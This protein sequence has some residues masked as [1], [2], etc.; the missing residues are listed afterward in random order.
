MIAVP[1]IRRSNQARA[2]L[3]G[4][5]AFSALYLG[6][7]TLHLVTPTTLVPGAIDAAIPL[8][9]WTVWIYLSQFLLLPGAIAFARDDTDRSQTFYAMLLAAV[10]AALIF[11]AWPTTMVRQTPA[12]D[13]LTGLAWRLLHFADPPANCFPSLHVALAVIAARALWRRGAFALATGWPILIAASTLSTRQHVAADIVG[14]LLLAALALW[15]TPRI[16]RLDPA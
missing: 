10:V 9:D 1:G 16:L 11:L 3:L 13:G 14:G 2:M 15:L 7:G 12:T 6:S 4:Y 5:L 8:V